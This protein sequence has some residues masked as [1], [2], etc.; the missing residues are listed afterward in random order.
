MSPQQN[1]G[2]GWREITCRP[3]ARP[4]CQ[5]AHHP[6]R[7]RRSSSSGRAPFFV[8]PRVKKPGVPRP[9]PAAVAYQQMLQEERDRKNHVV[10]SIAECVVRVDEQP[11]QQTLARE[12]RV[13]SV[14]SLCCDGFVDTMFLWLVHLLVAE[15]LLL[16]TSYH[17]LHD[18]DWH[19]GPSLKTYGMLRENRIEVL[20]WLFGAATLSGLLFLLPVA[21]FASSCDKIG[22]DATFYIFSRRSGLFCVS[23]FANPGVV[24]SCILLLVF[25]LPC[26]S[27]FGDLDTRAF[28]VFLPVTISICLYFAWCAL[29]TKRAK[30]GSDIAFLR[31]Q[32]F[33]VETIS[34]IFIK[35]ALFVLTEL[36]V[37]VKMENIYNVPWMHVI[38]PLLAMFGIVLIESVFRS[39]W[40]YRCF[41]KHL[42]QI[43]HQLDLIAA[44]DVSCFATIAV[45]VAYRLDHPEM[46][47]WGKTIAVPIITLFVLHSIWLILDFFRHV[48]SPPKPKVS[49]L[50]WL[51]PVVVGLD[52]DE[53]LQFFEVQPCPLPLR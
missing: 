14:K 12:V 45:L 3:A 52:M 37:I 35:A 1:R 39:A 38:S 2:C 19:L 20:Y 31:Y 13:Q 36:L 27:S 33:P 9:S 44:I 17:G 16:F 53:E 21:E 26:C 41:S 28:L 43:P 25:H 32:L 15:Q 6:H 46:M 47:L 50:A 4:V 29:E 48:Y 18:L 11:D 51:E 23:L 40:P 24:I 10:E 22:R 49:R 34:L 5:C 8:S 42:N 7:V 30:K